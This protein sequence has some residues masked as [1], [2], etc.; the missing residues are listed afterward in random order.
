M[1][2]TDIQGCTATAV[3]SVTQ[4]DSS[5]QNNTNVHHSGSHPA[6]NA[7]YSNAAFVNTGTA[8]YIQQSALL[9]CKGDFI[10]LS[11]SDSIGKVYNDGV[12]EL[13]GNFESDSGTI[14]KVGTNNSSTDRAV[15]FIGT[16]SQTIKG[17]MSTAGHSSFYN[18]VVDQAK[19][20]SDTVAYMLT[21]AG[22]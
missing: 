22:G 18:L 8:I 4:P 7:D 15:K 10:N 5:A 11:S 12:I 21:A 6:L 16:G 1:T 2:I 17:A 13:T 9:A 3:A 20:R 14:F 19:Q